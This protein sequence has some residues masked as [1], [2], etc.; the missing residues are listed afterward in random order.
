[1]CLLVVSR[2]SVAQAFFM[3]FFGTSFLVAILC[4]AVI[5]RGQRTLLDSRYLRLVFGISG[6][7]FSLIPFTG[8]SIT[9]S[10]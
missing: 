4:G 5:E 8:E 10:S 7:L 3:E 1:M 9:N 2:V 6:I